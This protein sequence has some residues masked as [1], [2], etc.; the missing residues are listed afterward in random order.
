MVNGGGKAARRAAA[1]MLIAALTAGTAAAETAGG[2]TANAF[3]EEAKSLRG[4]Q[5]I[6]MRPEPRKL[7]AERIARAL[8]AQEEAWNR[9][10]VDAFMT[11]YWKSED[12]RF[13]TGGTVIM[14]WQAGLGEFHVRYHSRE[15]MGR[16]SLSDFDIRVLSDDAALAFGRWK[17]EH[18]G[19]TLSGLFTQL[20]RKIGGRWV[21]VHDHTSS[22]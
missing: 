4:G 17:L 12:L 19:D 20:F 9:G 16:L 5:G 15:Q 21:I 8:V 2:R 11:G 22:E 6:R 14:G 3:L 1:G 10:D 13:A 18:N 7:Q